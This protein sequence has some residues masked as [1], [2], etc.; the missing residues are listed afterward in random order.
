MGAEVAPDGRETI[1]TEEQQKK[2]A[3]DP[4]EFLRVRKIVDQALN[5][6][7]ELHFKDSDLQKQAVQQYSAQ[8]RKRLGK[9]GDIADKLIPDFGVGCRR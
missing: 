2:W 4:K 6:L 1:F 5:H 3:E 8:M 9:K 7:F